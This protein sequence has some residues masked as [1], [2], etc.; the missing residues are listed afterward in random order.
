M[1]N[2]L[3]G[4]FFG[5]HM[6]ETFFNLGEAKR[7]RIVDATLEE[8]SLSGYEKTS[9]DAIVRRAGISKGGLY[10]Y[11]D[12]KE[13]LF[14]YALEYSYE[15]M[16]AGIGERR[17]PEELSPDPVER[18]R[19]IASVA[20]DFYL[21]RPEIIPF[22]VKASA[23]EYGEIKRRVQGAFDAYFARLYRGC[24]FSSMRFDGE[25]VTQLLKWLLAKTRNDFAA[26]VVATKRPGLCKSAYLE[27]WE[28]FFS[29]LAG[30]L[31]RA[32]PEGPRREKE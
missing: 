7:R 12:S 17:G 32:R 8:F 5:N 19:Q 2:R 11:I 28:F 30:G 26:N 21:E 14:Q 23:V 9:L 22:L 18:T 27:E 3:I 16:F 25:R 24:D 4:R 20:V 6:K 10:E 31:Y 1:K 13:D 29:V 15:A